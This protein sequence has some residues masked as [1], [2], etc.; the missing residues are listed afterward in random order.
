MSEEKKEIELKQRKLNKIALY[1]L[2][3]FVL[4]YGIQT[5]LFISY[6]EI[7]D[8]LLGHWFFTV[9]VLAISFTGILLCYFLAKN[10]VDLKN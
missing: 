8:N 1:V 6:P 4:L 10:Q 5:T 9:P 3:F 7:V 2:C